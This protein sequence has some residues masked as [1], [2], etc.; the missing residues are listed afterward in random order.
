MPR[1]KG[2][3]PEQKLQYQKRRVVDQCE[4]LLKHANV[5]KIEIAK[6]LGVTGS[7]ISYQFKSGKISI[8]TVIAVA[9]LT[10]AAPEDIELRAE[11]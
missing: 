6:L 1:V 5:K 10:N 7:A 9:T 4:L 3:T 2:L 11:I 8:D